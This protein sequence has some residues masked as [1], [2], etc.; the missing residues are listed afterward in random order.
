MTEGPPDPFARFARLYGRF[1]HHSDVSELRA[2]LVPLDDDWI[3][4]VGGGAGAVAAPFAA[5]GRGVVVADPSAAMLRQIRPDSG[6]LR[7]R[8]VAEAL[9]FADG[10]FSRIVVVDAFHHFE[11]R[12]AA[13]RELWRLLAPGGRLVIEELDIRY[14]SVRALAFGEWIL[15]F[16][17]VFWEPPRI[18]QAFTYLGAKTQVL[19]KR[20]RVARILIEKAGPEASSTV[21]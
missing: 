8:A 14:R 9:P 4:D 16:G 19:P 7:V 5:V 10:A 15:R 12:P 20:G 17:S 2:I 11:S 13:T 3:L 21:N 18:A 1:S 6:L